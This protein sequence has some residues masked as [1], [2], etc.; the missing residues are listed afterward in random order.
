LLGIF[1]TGPGGVVLG[2]VAGALWSM[3]RG[4]RNG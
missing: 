4:V 1:I 2:A 3:L